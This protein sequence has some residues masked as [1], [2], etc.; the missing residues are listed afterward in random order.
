VVRDVFG[1][2]Y[3]PLSRFNRVELG[4]HAVGISQATLE[5]Q[6]VYQNGGYLGTNVYNINGPTVTYVQ[7]SVAFVHDKSLF[8]YTGPFAGARDRWELSPSFGTWRYTQGLV[9]MRRYFF[10]RPFTLAL[11]G[12]FLGRVGRDGD[13]FPIYLGTTEL[14]RGYTAGSIFNNECTKDSLPS[15]YTGCATLDQLIGSRIAVANVEL[16][17]PLAR[18]FVLGFLPVGF[19][20]IEGA[21]FYDAGMAWQSGD[22]LKFSRA[23]GENPAFVR[24][25]LKSYGASIRA[26]VLG[27]VILRFDYTKPIDRPGKHPYWTVSL[28][29]TF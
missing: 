28:G 24:A 21:L 13:R 14:I 17:F 4:A 3:Y 2:A 10:A 11:R 12:M 19:P 5:I 18:N 9:D 25:P 26:N 8:G 1:E 27:W 23:A 29:P 6:D 15:S 7:P 20:P 22:T 16:R